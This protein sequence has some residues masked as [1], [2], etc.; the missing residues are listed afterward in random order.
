MI[1]IDDLS[2]RIATGI[3]GDDRM[4]WKQIEESMAALSALVDEVTLLRAENRKL[5]DVLEW[6]NNQC[7]G[8]CAG[9]C[10][11]AL[12]GEHHKENP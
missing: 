1:D 12:R 7:P 11:A 8:K 5:R 9:V 10:D 3:Y 2:T 4:S 6:V